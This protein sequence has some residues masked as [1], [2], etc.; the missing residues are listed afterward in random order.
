M[1]V[2]RGEKVVYAIRFTDG[3]EQTL[4]PLYQTGANHSISADEIEINTKD[5]DGAEYG[6]VTETI[7]FEGLIA[8]DDPALDRIKSDLR[9]K[10]MVEIL[11]IN[12]DT[13]DAEAGMYMVSSL[14]FDYP[15]DESATYSFSA[16]LNG[17]MTEETL[18]SVPTGATEI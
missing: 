15:D 13:L 12:T 9:N 7:G 10:N 2:L 4:R 18:V 6:K 11:K 8:Q 14:E 17:E 3:T 1:A 5:I 16:R